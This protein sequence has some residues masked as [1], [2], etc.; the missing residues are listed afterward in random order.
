MVNSNP[1]FGRNQLAEWAEKSTNGL[2][3]GDKFAQECLTPIART[4]YGQGAEMNGYAGVFRFR[5]RLLGQLKVDVV[6]I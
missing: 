3:F 1:Y 4:L 2:G 5:F 6:L